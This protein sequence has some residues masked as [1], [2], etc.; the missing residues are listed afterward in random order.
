[1]SAHLALRIAFLLSL[2]GAVFS[3]VLSYREM[4]GATALACPAPG[5]AGTVFGY[6]ACIY[7]FGM[8]LVLTAVTGAGLWSG[9]RHGIARPL[10][11]DTLGRDPWHRRHAE[12]DS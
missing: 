5:A 7:G 9:R 11:T 1:M 12:R 10:S 3:G 2:A 4:F 8:F 6:P